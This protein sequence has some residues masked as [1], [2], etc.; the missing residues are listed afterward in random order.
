[1]NY[2]IAKHKNKQG[3]CTCHNCRRSADLISIIVKCMFLDNAFD[4]SNT[5]SLFMDMIVVAVKFCESN[6]DFVGTWCPYT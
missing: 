5:F 4:K 2:I 1:M 6:S 3:I